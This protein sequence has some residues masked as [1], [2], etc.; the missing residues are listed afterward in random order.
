M[1]LG[2]LKITL[3]GFNEMIFTTIVLTAC[4][5]RNTNECPE[6]HLNYDAYEVSVMTCQMR[7]MEAIAKFMDGKPQQYVKRWKCVSSRDLAEKA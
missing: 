6:Y 3:E 7:G 5:Y 2:V 4:F 1:S